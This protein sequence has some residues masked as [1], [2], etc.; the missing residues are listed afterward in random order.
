MIIGILQIEFL[1]PGVRSL[2]GKR[3]I[4]KG[5]K[6]RIRKSFNVSISE[7]DYHDKWQRCVVTIA[8]VNNDKRQVE[9][10]FSKALNS[11]QK[12]G[13]IQILKSQIE[14]L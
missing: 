10:T 13:E 6:D 12:C 5:L 14:L 2:K 4:V 1:I 9:S 11:I 3:S 8:C 7:T